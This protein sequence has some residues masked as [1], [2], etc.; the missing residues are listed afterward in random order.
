M[1]K[2][3][4]SKIKEIFNNLKDRKIAV[5]GDVMLDVYYWGDTNRIS[6]EAPVPVID[7]T[8]EEIKPGGAANVGV[9][10]Q[11]STE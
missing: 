5:I 4:S 10:V 2:I 6:P 11:Y 7:I 1:V 8:H 9:L 3:K